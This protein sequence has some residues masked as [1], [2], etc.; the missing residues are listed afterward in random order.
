MGTCLSY[1]LSYVSKQFLCVG[2]SIEQ[3]E[4]LANL[5][6]KAQKAARRDIAH[7]VSGT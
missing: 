1:L 2:L 3:L 5:G 4:R 7:I 6:T